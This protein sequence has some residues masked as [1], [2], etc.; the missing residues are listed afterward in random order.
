[1]EGSHLAQIGDYIRL[2]FMRQ[3]PQQKNEID[4]RMHLDLLLVGLK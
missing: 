1:M 2:L 4:I 3:S